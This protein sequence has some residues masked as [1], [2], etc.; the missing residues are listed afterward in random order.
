MK[1]TTNETAVITPTARVTARNG[2]PCRLETPANR[3]DDGGAHAQMT[4]I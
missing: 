3:A 1:Q 4:W 2:T